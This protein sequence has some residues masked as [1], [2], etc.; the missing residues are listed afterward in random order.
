MPRGHQDQGDRYELQ[1][2]Q[3]QYQQQLQQM[4]QQMQQQQQQLQQQQQQQQQYQRQLQ[5]L[6]QQLD[7]WVQN[8]LFYHYVIFTIS[9]FSR[10]AVNQSV[11][12]RGGS[13]SPNRVLDEWVTFEKYI[14]DYE[15]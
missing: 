10:L 5:Q 2:Q 3:Q 12:R 13:V 7:L 6:Q 4:Q 9:F 1:V 15:C 14:C 8:Y 11:H